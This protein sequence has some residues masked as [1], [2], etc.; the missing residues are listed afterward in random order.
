MKGFK[1]FL[2]K[3]QVL[4]LAVAVIMGGAIG[5]VVSS[6]VADI[7]MPFISLLIPGGEWR[8]A[9]FVLSS[10]VGPDGKEVINALSYGTFFGSLVDFVVI[11]FCVYMIMKALIKEAPA[12][13][14]APTKQCPRCTETIPLAAKKCKYCTT[15]LAIGQVN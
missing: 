15:D 4:G 7:L 1:E 2:L 10:N 13:A 5:K 11:G 8:A 12:P 14:I 3:N 9:K 6:L